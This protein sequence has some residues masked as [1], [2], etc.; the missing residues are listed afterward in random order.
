MYFRA[1]P[2]KN[3]RSHCLR[4]GIRTRNLPTNICDGSCIITNWTAL[5]LIVNGNGAERIPMLM[6]RFV[7]ERWAH[8][9]GTLF[10]SMPLPKM[11]AHQT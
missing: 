10:T 9:R 7:K 8:W 1:T 6:Q 3:I 11:N 4:K 2:M 5:E